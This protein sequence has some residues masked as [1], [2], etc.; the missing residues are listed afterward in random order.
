MR[1]TEA[2]ED[3]TSRLV[4][5]NDASRISHSIV[6]PSDDLSMT[7]VRLTTEASVEH[8]R[9]MDR[10]RLASWRAVSGFP[11]DGL[12]RASGS[13]LD[14]DP[15]VDPPM[16]SGV[17]LAFTRRRALLRAMGSRALVLVQTIC[18]DGC[19]RR[20][21]A[22]LTAIR[23]PIHEAPSDHKSYK[24]FVDRLPLEAL[25]PSLGGWEE[26]TL[27]A[28]RDFWLRRLARDRA[29]AQALVPGTT[30]FFQPGLFDR[31]ADREHGTITDER[32]D[33]ND[34]LRAS[35]RAA[36]RAAD[37]TVRRAQFVLVLVPGS[38]Q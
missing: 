9:L 2:E 10:R 31:R 11:A 16:P 12:D 38:R 26:K 22:H 1:S 14:S 21:G 23:V 3:A 24:R 17:C 6:I 35:I 37:A 7:F 20:V 25:D 8:A 28:H 32:R 15:A 36:E 34:D 30:D 5:N 4:V 29:V 13:P 18:E 33:F 27:R 19:G